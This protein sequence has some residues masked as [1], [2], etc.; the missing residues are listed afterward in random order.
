M[1]LYI[2]Q[3]RPYVKYLII[4]FVLALLVVIFTPST[5]VLQEILS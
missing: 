4:A 5:A 3:P 2:I 1:K